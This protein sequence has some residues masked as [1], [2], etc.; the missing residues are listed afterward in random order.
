MRIVFD[1]AG[2]L[3][4]MGTAQM[5]MAVNGGITL[6][7]DGSES[8]YSVKWLKDSKTFQ[9][10]KQDKSFWGAVKSWFSHGLLRGHT[11]TRA[12]RI[13]EALNQRM[14]ELEKA[15]FATLDSQ[16]REHH[17]TPGRVGEKIGSA[18]SGGSPKREVFLYGF[19]QQRHNLRQ[20]LAPVLQNP[21]GAAMQ[22]TTIDD[23]NSDLG[24]KWGLGFVDYLDLLDEA[25]SGTLALRS[26]KA[27]PGSTRDH[28]K[29]AEFLQANHHKLDIARHKDGQ[30][31]TG[32][33]FF[34]KNLSAGDPN[35]YTFMGGPVRDA[36][37]DIEQDAKL[38]QGQRRDPAELRKALEAAAEEI[39]AVLEIATDP[40]IPTDQKKAAYNR[41][42]EE[43]KGCIDWLATKAFF[44]KTSKLGLEFAR[45]QGA[46][47][48]FAWRHPFYYE[49]LE[50]ALKEKPWKALGGRGKFSEAITFSEM[51]KLARLE[52]QGE[53][54]RSFRFTDK[55]NL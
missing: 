45:S 18:F 33:E 22:A 46:P 47:V 14:A 9:V 41:L 55:K 34:A 10:E 49:K 48:A 37:N 43:D 44:R 32:A 1:N 38:P 15:P 5:R 19:A 31:D 3:R 2:S 35:D 40:N 52:T 36:M 30:T 20:S 21:T 7:K 53:A 50:D 54:P 13:A 29:W 39:R 51:R 8:T 23:Y 27:P 24:I 25:K 17:W 11:H 42:S 26:D 16:N 4:E 6:R 12:E 28:R